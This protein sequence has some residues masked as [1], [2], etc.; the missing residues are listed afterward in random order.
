MQRF[1]RTGSNEL[2][3]HSTA[4]TSKV[5]NV[6]NVENLENV[7]TGAKYCKDLQSAIFTSL[8]GVSE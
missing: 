4:S 3:G 2:N 7:E 6:E 1:P 8:D 5:E